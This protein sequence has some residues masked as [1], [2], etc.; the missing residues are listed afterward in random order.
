MIGT[1]ILTTN[2]KNFVFLVIDK[3]KRVD[4]TKK[5]ML[6]NIMLVTI[7]QSIWIKIW[8]ETNNNLFNNWY[9]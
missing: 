5:K 4:H 8:V 1:F 6:Y 7:Q 3:T 2:K 9:S